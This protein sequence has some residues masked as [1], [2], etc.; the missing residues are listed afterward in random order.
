MVCLCMSK[1]ETQQPEDLTLRLLR[2]VAEDVGTL[3]EGQNHI[4]S[5]LIALRNELHT[6]RG[7]SLRRD[8]VVAGLQLDSDR[9]K[10]RL[11]LSDA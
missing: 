10:S 4:R 7:D 8:E 11:N 6:M 9:I 5:E 2:G 1:D 3:K